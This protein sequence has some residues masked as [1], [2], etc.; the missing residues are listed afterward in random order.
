[1]CGEGKDIFL[2]ILVHRYKRQ[3]TL[4]PFSLLV[5]RRRH[6]MGSQMRILG[7]IGLRTPVPE[8]APVP[9][10]LKTHQFRASD[11]VILAVGDP[12]KQAFL[13]RE[14]PLITLAAEGY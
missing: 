14:V 13:L 5:L 4:G 1:M 9:V 2:S 10:V 11:A 12:A 6:A 7:F 8:T 3:N